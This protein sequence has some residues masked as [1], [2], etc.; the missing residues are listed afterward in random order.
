MSDFIFGARSVARLEECHVELRRVAVRA[1]GMSPIDFTIVCG[2]RGQAEQ[3][4]A[5]RKGF[6]KTPWPKSRHNLTPSDAFDFAPFI[7]G[8]IPWTDLGAFY[9][10]AGVIRAAAKIERVAIRYGGDWDGDGETTDNRFQDIGHV[11]RLV[12]LE[13]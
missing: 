13:A 5:Y 3:E 2:H 1:L 12:N 6:S 8:R 7:R 11:E 4:E 9:Q 10:I